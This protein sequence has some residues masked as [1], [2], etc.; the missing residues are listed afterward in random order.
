MI[1]VIQEETKQTEERE[2]AG[3]RSPTWRI[4]RALQQI[5]DA[6]RIEVEAIM[7]SPPFFESAG[8][9]E[10]TFWGKEK[11]ATVVIRES[12]LESEKVRWLEMASKNKLGCLVQVKRGGG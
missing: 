4:L 9:G 12:L 5:N 2:E 7:S 3:Y 8:R 11:G 10:L 6:T 1:A